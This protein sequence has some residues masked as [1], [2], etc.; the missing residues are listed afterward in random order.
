MAQERITQAEIAKRSHS[1]KATMTA[2]QIIIFTHS[3]PPNKDLSKAPTVHKKT[4]L[5][6][7]AMV[8]NFDGNGSKFIMAKDVKKI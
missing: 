8:Q 6:N 1:N 3:N 5:R 7:K 2:D 4:R